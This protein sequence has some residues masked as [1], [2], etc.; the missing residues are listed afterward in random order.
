M[1]KK[2]RRE[3]NMRSNKMHSF[4]S[5]AYKVLITL[6]ND[7]SKVP[8]LCSYILHGPDQMPII[9]MLPR[10]PKSQDFTH[11]TPLYVVSQRG[12]IRGFYCNSNEIIQ[13][14]MYLH[15]SPDSNLDCNSLICASFPFMS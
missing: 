5:K 11:F 15:P 10:L 3:P 9:T 8:I 2:F 14:M 13:K 7:Y 6:I 12:K 1:H 4:A